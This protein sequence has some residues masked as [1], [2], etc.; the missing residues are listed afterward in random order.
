MATLEARVSSI[1]AQMEGQTQVLGDLRELI[2]ALDRKIDRG[3]EA[4]DRRFDAID[5]RFDAIDRRFEAVDGRFL[6]IEDR[7]DQRLSALE[8]KM[9]RRF[10]VVEQRIQVIDAKGDRHFTWLVGIQLTSLVTF[11][12]TLLGMVGMLLRQ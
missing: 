4:A 10:E 1:E 5:R 12:A 9:D 6:A 11:A 8:Q 2:V 7:F 3:F